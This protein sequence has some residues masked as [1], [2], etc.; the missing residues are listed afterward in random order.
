M[1]CM[2]YLICIALTKA[3]K[4]VV[5]PFVPFKIVNSGN[6]NIISVY[7]ITNMRLKSLLIRI[8]LPN[9]TTYS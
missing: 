5:Y 4:K 9:N 1:I 3:L 6:T 2:R 8:M 7:Y